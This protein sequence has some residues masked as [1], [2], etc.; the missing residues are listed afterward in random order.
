MA[1]LKEIAY[2]LIGHVR[3]SYSDDDDLDIRQVYYWVKNQRAVW[4]NNKLSEHK[5]IS[6]KLI[7]EY[8]SIAVSTASG[9]PNE[10]RTTTTIAI[11]FFHRGEPKLLYVG[12]TGRAGKKLVFIPYESAKYHGSGRFNEDTACSYYLN[13]YVYVRSYTGSTISIR[14]IFED[15]LDVTG[16]T[17]DS[18]YPI[19]EN[20]L[21]Y[22][23]AEILKADMSIFLQSKNDETNDER[24]DNN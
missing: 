5:P 20:L 14:G 22:L 13:G 7:Q 4:V 3:P 23:K 11:P 9:A 10:K 18:E 8:A 16:Y 15:P 1:T 24:N 12:P 2:D 17:V 19:D 6:E 21:E